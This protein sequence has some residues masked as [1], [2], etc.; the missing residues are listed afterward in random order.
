MLGRHSTAVRTGQ[1]LSGGLA[2]VLAAVTANDTD[3]RPSAVPAG[4]I[5]SLRGSC[6]RCLLRGFPAPAI[7][8]FARNLLAVPGDAARAVIGV[9]AEFARFVA[10]SFIAE[11][12]TRCSRCW[13]RR[14]RSR[15]CSGLCRRWRSWLCRWR[16]G[17]RRPC[18]GGGCWRC[19]G[20]G[21][22]RPERCLA[23]AG[24]AVVRDA[25]VHNDAD[26]WYGAADLEPH[27]PGPL[28]TGWSGCVLFFQ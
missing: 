23:A 9:A 26:A 22:P 17:G 20:R 1:A 27:S 28:A 19:R 14:G 18:R 2:A 10:G 13:R 3:P 11:R 25:H 21:C 8:V 6:E 5:P 12:V 4:H 16:R 24:A 15:W 7:V